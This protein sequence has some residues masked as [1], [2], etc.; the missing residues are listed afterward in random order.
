MVSYN[1]IIRKNLRL[2]RAANSQRLQW[3]QS[4]WFDTWKKKPTYHQWNNHEMRY[5][6]SNGTAEVVPRSCYNRRLSHETRAMLKVKIKE[7]EA[8]NTSSVCATLKQTRK[9]KRARCFACKE[10]GHVVWNC[11]H[12]RNKMKGKIE[13]SQPRYTEELKYPEVVHVTT[14]FMIN[15]SG[16]KDW[17]RIWYISKE[18]KNHMTPENDQTCVVNVQTLNRNTGLILKRI[19]EKI[20]NEAAVVLYNQAVMVVRLTHK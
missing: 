3:H 4:R 7:N 16:E 13:A 18:Y 17:N 5:S 14:D 10:R 6:L 12:K 1:H 11:P 15:G 8:Y 19:P 2:Q 9:D 20:D